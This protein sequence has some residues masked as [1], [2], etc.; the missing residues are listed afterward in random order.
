VI[1]SSQ[2]QKPSRPAEAFVVVMRELFNE[3]D[4]LET[5]TI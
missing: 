1:A 2:A 5:S 3:T 4:T